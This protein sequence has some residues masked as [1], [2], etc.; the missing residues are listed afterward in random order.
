MHSVNMWTVILLILFDWI[1]AMFRSRGDFSSHEEIYT[2][3]K[4]LIIN[5]IYVTM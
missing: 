1:L 5:K 4:I 2:T 3:Y